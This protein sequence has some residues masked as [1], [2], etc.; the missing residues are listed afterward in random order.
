MAKPKF[1]AANISA[2]LY[3]GEAD[4]R[5]ECVGSHQCAL[6][7]FDVQPPEPEDECVMRRGYE[8]AHPLAVK[9]ALRD[10]RDRITAKLERME[11][12]E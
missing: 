10:L 3:A 7:L 9:A 8:C 2:S 6:V 1:K 11:T 5:F 12:D 4:I